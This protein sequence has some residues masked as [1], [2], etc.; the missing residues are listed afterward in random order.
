M[1]IYNVIRMN[2]EVMK[3]QKRRRSRDIVVSRGFRLFVCLLCCSNLVVFV[4][5]LLFLCV[6]ACLLTSLCFVS[7][8]GDAIGMGECG[9]TGR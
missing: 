8:D 4:F 2:E 7:W 1:D 6:Y 5:Y 3:S 9:V